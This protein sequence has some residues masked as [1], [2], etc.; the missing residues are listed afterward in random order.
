MTEVIRRNLQKLSRWWVL[1]LKNGQ[2]TPDEVLEYNDLTS[3]LLKDCELSD[4][5]A[6]RSLAMKVAATKLKGAR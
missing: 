6:L 2:R 4:E 3:C 1:D 5:N